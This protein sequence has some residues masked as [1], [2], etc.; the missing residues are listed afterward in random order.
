MR[1]Q[2]FGLR[3]ILC[4]GSNDRIRTRCIPFNTRAQVQRMVTAKLRS[5]IFSPSVTE[6]DAMAY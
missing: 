1:K 5:G 4:W 2:V 6:S 3:E